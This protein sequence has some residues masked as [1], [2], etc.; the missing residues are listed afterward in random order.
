MKVNSL[1]PTIVSEDP[2]KTIQFYKT[3]GFEVKHDAV[4][5]LGSHV[6][7]LSNGALEIEILEHVAGGPVE[8]PVGFYGMRMNVSDIDEAY[9]ELQAQGCTVVKP[10]FETKT[11]NM[12]MMIKDA[13]GVNIT[14]IQHIK[15]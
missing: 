14:L 6:Y 7:V 12:N 4:T 13:D 5:A 2:N 9:Q 15:K 1:Y 8:L 10:P 3:M 11:G